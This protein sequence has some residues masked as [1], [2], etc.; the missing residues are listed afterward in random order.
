[1]PNQTEKSAAYPFLR[2]VDAPQCRSERI[3]LP[4]PERP[5]PFL[6]VRPH[7]RRHLLL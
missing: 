2:Y 4:R 7:L 3:H 5:Y 1:M 6:R